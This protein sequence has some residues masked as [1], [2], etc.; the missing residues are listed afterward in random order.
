MITLGSAAAQVII[1]DGGNEHTY[2][3]DQGFTTDCKMTFKN[4]TGKTTVL[5]YNQI[6]NT[7]PTA[8]WAVSF[9]DNRNCFP[10][11]VQQDS[12]A[13]LQKDEKSE[14][15]ISVDPQGKTD[16]AKLQYEVYDLDNPSVKDTVTFNF[17]VQWGAGLH[18]PLNSLVQ[19]YPNPTSSFINLHGITQNTEVRIYNAESKLAGVY[20]VSAENETI[21]VAELPAGFYF[22]SYNT[23]AGLV[24]AGFMKQ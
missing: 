12:F 14:F 23:N 1:V 5:A 10:S 6:Y 24:R 4:N 9:C 3:M 16:T 21:G 11:I 13:A 7:F 15:K 2:Y 17:I 8:K 22:V 18:E 19:V 20:R